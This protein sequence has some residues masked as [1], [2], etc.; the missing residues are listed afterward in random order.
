[1]G[2]TSALHHAFGGVLSACRGAVYPC[3]RSSALGAL[4]F[5]GRACYAT[6]RLRVARVGRSHSLGHADVLWDGSRMVV[7]DA[8]LAQGPP[9]GVWRP[10]VTAT[11]AKGL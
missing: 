1:M 9:R 6:A 10:R 4:A 2:R 3:R 5:A 8:S 11:A 7:T